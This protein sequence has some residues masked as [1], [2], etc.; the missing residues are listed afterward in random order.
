[1]AKREVEILRSLLS[2][3]SLRISLADELIQ[4]AIWSPDGRSLALGVAK[5]R[6]A[7]VVVDVETGKIDPVLVPAQ[8][9]LN[10]P[11]WHE[12]GESLYACSPV[13]VLRT[14]R[15]A[16]GWRVVS[17][18]ATG[19]PVNWVETVL[20]SGCVGMVVNPS[21][22]VL[23]DQDMR[24]TRQAPMVTK[25]GVGLHASSLEIP[26]WHDLGTSVLCTADTAS[27]PALWRVY[28]PDEHGL[29]ACS[30]QWR[31]NARLHCLSRALHCP[32][33]AG[34]LTEG[35]EHDCLISTP[36]QLW[37]SDLDGSG[38]TPLASERVAPVHSP[39]SLSPD[40]SRV[41]FI[42]EDYRVHI[43]STGVARGSD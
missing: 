39:V 27:T 22:L 31:Q 28:L 29:Q 32:R 7:L 24:V 23:G 36:Q 15:S 43:L 37:V 21:G 6:P 40:G 30:M 1:V 8:P 3:R 16:R 5:P 9:G 2:P 41:S 25:D 19:Y 13:R 11:I 33:L 10:R 34:L 17:E 26:V 38:R 35:P 20:S 18:V 12:D 42:D 14:R 4:Y